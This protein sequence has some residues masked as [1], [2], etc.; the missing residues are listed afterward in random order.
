M[1]NGFVLDLASESVKALRPRVLAGRMII[2][3]A[4]SGFTLHEPD[5]F[6][7]F[8]IDAGGRTLAQLTDLA[9]DHVS[10]IPVVDA[11]YLWV[12]V[13]FLRGDEASAERNEKID[14]LVSF[15]KER[16]W[17]DEQADAVRAH[18][19]GVSG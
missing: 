9:T 16:G 5:D 19:E 13:A 7:R 10:V 11:E 4:D 6:S 1:S 17:Y 18:V 3:A 8:H 2:N 12:S 14:H 15:A